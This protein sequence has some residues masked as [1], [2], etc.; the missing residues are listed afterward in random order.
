MERG[1]GASPSPSRRRREKFSGTGPVRN[2]ML[3]HI[4]DW[5]NLMW[6]YER[7]ARGKRGDFATMGR[8][9]PKIGFDPTYDCLT[10]LR[11]IARIG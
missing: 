3:E 1:S 6:A 8:I 4:Y 7:A 10:H 2:T 9:V 11:L 5:D